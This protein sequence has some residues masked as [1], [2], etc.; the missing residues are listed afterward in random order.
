MD[1]WTEREETITKV[2]ATMADPMKVVAQWKKNNSGAH[3]IMCMGPADQIGDLEKK[4]R[5]KHSKDMHVYCSR[6]TYLELAP[7]SVS[8]GSALKLVLQKCFKL[9][10]ATALAFGDNYN[11]L[12]MLEVA[13]WGVAVANAREEVKAVANEITLKSIENG[14]AVTLGKYATYFI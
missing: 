10:L 5:A 2:K 6:S 9:E 3:K 8:K 1:H 12:E 11:D 13:G 4:L 14:V 7:K